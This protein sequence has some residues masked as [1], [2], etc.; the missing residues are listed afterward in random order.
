[1]IPYFV[2]V[3]RIAYCNYNFMQL[4][5]INNFSEKVMIFVENIKTNEE[6]D[7]KKIKK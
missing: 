7:K 5:M 2:C 4:N 6:K 3:L 1:M